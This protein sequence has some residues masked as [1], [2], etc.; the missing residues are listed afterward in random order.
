M[1]KHIM[2]TAVV[3]LFA[4]SLMPSVLSGEPKRRLP[5]PPEPWPPD[6]VWH[7]ISIPDARPEM[8]LIRPYGGERWIPAYTPFYL[9]YGWFFIPISLAYDA[10]TKEP[11]TVYMNLQDR[12]DRG[13][14]MFEHL[15]FDGVEMEPTASYEAS[16]RWYR[17]YNAGVPPEDQP[18]FPEGDW[19]VAL[20]AECSEN[21]I[22]FPDGLAPGDYTVRLVGRL[23]GVGPVEY[24]TILHVMPPITFTSEVVST[25]TFHQQSPDWPEWTYEGDWRWRFYTDYFL[26]YYRFTVNLNGLP[27]DESYTFQYTVDHTFAERLYYSSG[28]Q[29]PDW[30]DWT[31]VEDWTNDYTVTETPPAAGFTVRTYG[32]DPQPPFPNTGGWPSYAYVYWFSE[33]QRLDPELGWTYEGYWNIYYDPEWGWIYEWVGGYHYEISGYSDVVSASIEYKGYTATWP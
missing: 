22:I 15:Y 14:L 12:T 17:F 13:N 6:E 11:V 26:G 3:L 19:A 25:W 32:E 5:P 31:T 33:Q 30:P 16:C 2:I 7:P 1:K 28:Y 8:L 9:R 18:P 27:L 29:S 10:E 21:H 20:S 4:L 23:S 24:V